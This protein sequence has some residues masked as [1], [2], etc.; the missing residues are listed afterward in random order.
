[1]FNKI[2]CKQVDDGVQEINDDISRLADSLENMLKILG[3][4]CER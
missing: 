2:N 3:K 4:R 1:M